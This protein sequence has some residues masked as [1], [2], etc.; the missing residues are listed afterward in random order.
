VSLQMGYLAGGILRFLARSY[1]S[2]WTRY[3]CPGTKC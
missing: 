1:L 3:R 2:G